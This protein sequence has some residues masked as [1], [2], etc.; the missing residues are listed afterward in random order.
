MIMGR[1]CLQYTASE[2][3]M[4]IFCNTKSKTKLHPLKDFA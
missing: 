4:G 1:M 3:K 2:D